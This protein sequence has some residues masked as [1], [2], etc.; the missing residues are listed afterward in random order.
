MAVEKI[1]F[2]ISLSEKIW[3]LIGAFLL[4]IGVQIFIFGLL[5]GIL[6]KNYY[7]GKGEMNYSIKEIIEN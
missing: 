3:P 1:F 7:R 6:M 2:D 5:A 4:M